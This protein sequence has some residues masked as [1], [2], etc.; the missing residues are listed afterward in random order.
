MYKYPRTL[1]FKNKDS[2]IELEEYFYYFKMAE[3]Y[4]VG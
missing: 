2:L 4:L 1:N 3:L